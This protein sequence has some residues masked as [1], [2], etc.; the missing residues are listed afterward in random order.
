MR[1]T[2]S[3]GLGRLHFTDTVKVLDSMGVKVEVITGWIPNLLPAVFLDFIGR[4]LVDP[5][6]EEHEISSPFYQ[7]ESK[8]H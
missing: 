3:T 7:C 4:I 6:F 1:I 8:L 5:I 2:L